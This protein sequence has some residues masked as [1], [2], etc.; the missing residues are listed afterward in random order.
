[1]TQTCVACRVYVCISKDGRTS[2][3]QLARGRKRIVGPKFFTG[4]NQSIYPLQAMEPT[5]VARAI[6][7]FSANHMPS[8]MKFFW[9]EL[10]S[11]KIFSLGLVWKHQIPLGPSQA[12]K[13][14]RKLVRGQI[15]FPFGSPRQRV[16]KLETPVFPGANPPHLET[17]CA[18]SPA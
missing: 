14:T 15:A 2:K 18:A 6:Y 11:R 7:S 8:W 1:M 16:R 5:N 12:W 4:P 10:Q 3:T 17:S 9:M 13:P